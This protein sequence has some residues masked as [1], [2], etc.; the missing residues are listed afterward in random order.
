MTS[1]TAVELSP[2]QITVP[3]WL[4][5]EAKRP[6]TP[7]RNRRLKLDDYSPEAVPGVLT[8]LMPDR[9]LNALYNGIARDSKLPFISKLL[10]VEQEARWEINQP[11]W[12]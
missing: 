12:G 10:A 2:V 11:Y 1:M 3:G 5:K 6:L 9:Y 4:H 7:V 8:T